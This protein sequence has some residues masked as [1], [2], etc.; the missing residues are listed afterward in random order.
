MSSEFVLSLAEK[1]VFT[2]LLV[3]GPLL[4]LALAVGLLVSIFQATTQIQEQTLAF[5]PK[6]VAVLVGL[7]FFGPWMLTEMV[8]FTSDLF[9]NINQ[10]VG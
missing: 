1:G 3:T 7:I 2:I 6:I 10:F 9:Q 8:E 4:I 5:I